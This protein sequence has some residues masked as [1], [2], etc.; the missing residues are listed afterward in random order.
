MIKRVPGSIQV[1]KGKEKV[2]ALSLFARS[3]ARESSVISG[4]Y[5]DVFEKDGLGIP[6]PSN[7]VFWSVSHKP[8]F[9]AGIVSNEE[10]GIDLELIK[11]VSSALFD[12]V[13]DPGENSLFKNK[14]KNLIFF[15]TFTA[16]EAVL[17]KTGDGIKGLSG[18]KVIKVVDDTN[19]IVEYLD[20]KYLIENF[21]FDRYL[22]S[23]TK[24]QSDV[25]WAISKNNI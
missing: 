1:L 10:V 7:N 13:V 25:Q 8:G 14:D 11:D 19:L 18:A 20:N 9:V 2:I 24:D 6:K 15:R 5:V 12:R 3:C 23:V 4:C 17:K 22:A 21:Y 16:K